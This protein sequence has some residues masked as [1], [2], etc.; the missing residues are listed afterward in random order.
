MK[1]MRFNT[2]KE[3]YFLPEEL[4]NNQRLK[5]VKCPLCG[6]DNKSCESYPSVDCSLCN[7]SGY[8]MEEEC[9]VN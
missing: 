9:Q 8:V 2:L 6:G 5:K 4:K 7:G 1:D 3:K